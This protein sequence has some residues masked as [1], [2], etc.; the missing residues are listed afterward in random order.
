MSNFVEFVQVWVL[1]KRCKVGCL[2]NIEITD[3]QVC[4]RVDGLDGKFP[5]SN[6]NTL[7]VMIIL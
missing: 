3:I 2:K 1:Q 4:T 6:I 7:T 5:K